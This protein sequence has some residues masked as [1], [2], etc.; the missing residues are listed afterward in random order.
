VQYPDEA[1]ATR[2]A[3]FITASLLDI[4]YQLET[5]RLAGNT[6]EW[7][8]LPFLSPS[9]KQG[10]F[11]AYGPSF[12]I[13]PSSPQRQL[14]AWVFTKW[15][16]EPQNQ[17]RLVQANGSFPL[18]QSVLEQLPNHTRR[19]PQ[20]SAA[21]QILPL[22]HSEPP[23]HSWSTVRWALSDASTQLFRSYFTIDQVPQLLQYLDQT[24]TELHSGLDLGQIFA[25]PTDTPS[26]TETP[27]P[28]LTPTLTP[29]ATRTPLPTPS[30]TTTP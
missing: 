26:P 12:E 19:Y 16:L 10:G 15:L 6:D 25:T 14:A 11:D 3:L 17:A 29:T 7:S 22:A 20:W 13:I 30:Q 28:T 5:F 21:V 4:P 1:F 27:T 23:F 9:D 24:A 8:V 18:R 2:Q